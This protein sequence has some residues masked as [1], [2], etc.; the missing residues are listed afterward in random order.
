MS[1]PRRAVAA[2]VRGARARYQLVC[3]R[4]DAARLHLRVP[5]GVWF[6]DLCRHVL[7][8]HDSIVAHNLLCP[9]FA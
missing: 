3:A 6:C 4:E 1:K 8:D 2:L 7:L 9:E 5:S